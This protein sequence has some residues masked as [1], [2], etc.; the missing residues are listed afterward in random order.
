MA[1]AS[2]SQ[3]WLC[4][5]ARSAAIIQQQQWLWLQKGHSDSTCVK[6][7]LLLVVTLQNFYRGLTAPI[8][9]AVSFGRARLMQGSDGH[10]DAIFWK[11]EGVS[12]WILSLGSSKAKNPRDHTWCPV[13]TSVTFNI[14]LSNFKKNPESQ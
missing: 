9:T 13:V 4:K 14:N 2:K 3:V 5:C 10:N 8:S 1:M 6:G 12:W 11:A 7:L